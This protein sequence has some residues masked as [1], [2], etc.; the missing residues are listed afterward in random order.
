MIQEAIAILAGKQNLSHDAAEKVMDEI[1]LGQA[2][3]TQMAA[4]LTALHIKGETIAEITA[5]ASTI[6]KHGEKLEHN[7]DVM[8][9][10][11]TGGDCAGTINISTI[12]SFIVSAAGVNVAKH[13]NRAASSK[14]GTAD[15]LE[16]LG[17]NIAP[18]AELSSTILNYLGM[19]FLFAQKYH[20]AVKNVAS[21]R[22][23]IKIPTVFNILG[24]LTNPAHANMQLLGVYDESLVEPL[25]QVLS[26]LSVR[27]A[28]VVYGRDRL[29]E[30]SM[31][32]ETYVCELRDGALSTY[33]IRPEDY[34]F[35]R[36]NKGE[37]SGGNPD[38]NARITMEILRG[39][40]GPKTDA[41]ILNAGAAIYLAK[42]IPMREAI[43]LARYTL[44]SG[45]ALAQL[46]KFIAMTNE[47]EQP[48]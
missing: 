43:E 41:V 20:K 24:P 25:A 31:C 29:D 22:R 12:S 1:M 19:C 30:I 27:R 23:E 38:E 15:L 36:C 28:M 14:C 32:D 33:V 8:D 42:N 13:G 11:G 9:I 35:K 45:K 37:L 47:Q 4:F 21:V 26:N 48:C 18:S 2:N 10:V 3:S 6:R 39:S 44:E 34:G 17:V 16:V 46:E 7:L 40:K 5:F